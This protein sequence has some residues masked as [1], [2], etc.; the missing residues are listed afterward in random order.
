LA[1]ADGNLDLLNIAEIIDVP[2]WD[3]VELA[4]RL[5]SKDLLK[6]V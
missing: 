3:L 1:Y 5:K 2:L 4:D 6:P